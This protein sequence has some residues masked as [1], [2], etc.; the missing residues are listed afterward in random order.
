MMMRTNV[1]MCAV[2]LEVMGDLEVCQQ[3][4]QYTESIR[5]TPESSGAR[6]GGVGLGRVRIHHGYV[7]DG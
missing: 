1:A 3:H 5:H 7:R 6:K 4:W 2:V